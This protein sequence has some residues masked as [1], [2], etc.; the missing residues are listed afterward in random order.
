MSAKPISKAKLQPTRLAFML[1]ACLPT[2]AL[3]GPINTNVAL[4]PGTGGSIFRLQ[5]TYSESDGHGDV[6]HVNASVWRTTYA[7]GLKRNLALILSVPY[8]HRETDVLKPKLGRFERSDSGFADMTFLLKY[9]FWQND[10]RPGETWRWAVIGGMNIRSGDSDFTSDSYDPILGTAFTWR[11]DRQGLFA[12]LIHQF[13]T[14]GGEA[15]HDVLRYDVAYTYR[16][17][18]VRFETGKL[19]ELNAIA[20]M[21]GRYVT[22]GSHQ[23]FLS[24]GIQ[25]VAQRWV[26]ETA[27]QIPV[28]QDL[29]GPKTDYRFIVGFRYQW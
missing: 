22:D 18:P 2:A 11:R 9:R 29:A 13:N 20:E 3:A 17:A 19:W 24:P 5:Y 10:P 21:N 28:I 7:F 16:L 14:G 8:V 1:M 27:I 25:F 26:I 4:T 12:D 15:R 23:V 6:Q